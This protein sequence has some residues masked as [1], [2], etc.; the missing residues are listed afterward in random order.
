MQG[1]D[2]FRLD[3]FEESRVHD[4]RD[5]HL[6]GVEDFHVYFAEDGVEKDAQNQREAVVEGVFLLGA[7]T[8]DVFLAHAHRDFTLVFEPQLGVPCLRV[9]DLLDHHFHEV[10]NGGRRKFFSQSRVLLFCLGDDLH[11]FL[12]HA[13]LR[14]GVL[15]DGNFPE[16]VVDVDL[17]RVQEQHFGDRGDAQSFARGRCCCFC[18]GGRGSAIPT[19][20]TCTTCT[21][22]TNHLVALKEVAPLGFEVI[23]HFFILSSSNL[24]PYQG[25]ASVFICVL[26]VGRKSNINRTA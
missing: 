1:L 5:F 6:A 14:G 24:F 9:V 3:V 20:T 13:F 4:A 7:T 26:C 18:G 2:D 11:L 23:T 15:D 17:V 19:T 8:H 12:E 25:R 21:T 22:C 16:D 10:G